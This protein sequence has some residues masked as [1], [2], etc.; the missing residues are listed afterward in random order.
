MAKMNIPMGTQPG[1]VFTIK[2]KGMPHLRGSGRGDQHVVVQVEIPTK[3]S[4][5]QRKAFEDLGR[6]LGNEAKP[7]ERG[8]LEYL[9]EVLGG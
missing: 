1:K 6:M 3:L 7:T 8:F 5:E 2:G 9:K 4:V